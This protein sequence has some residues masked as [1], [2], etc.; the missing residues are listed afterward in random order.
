[1]KIKLVDVQQP[2]RLFNLLDTCEGPVVC[3]GMDL[4]HNQN[5][6]D[7]LCT[8]TAPGRGIPCLELNIAAKNDLSR[9]VRFMTR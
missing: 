5:L 7:L 6:R 4:R 1:M 8:L 3:C 2:Q 9:F